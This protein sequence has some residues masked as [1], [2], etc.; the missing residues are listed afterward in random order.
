M[1]LIDRPLNAS[2]AIET[3]NKKRP[4]TSPLSI[5]RLQISHFFSN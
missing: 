1:R 3:T 5:L 2:F 4:N